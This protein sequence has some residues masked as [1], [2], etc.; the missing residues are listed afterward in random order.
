MSKVDFSIL[1]VIRFLS[2]CE[3]LY[4]PEQLNDFSGRRFPVL[5]LFYRD[6]HQADIRIFEAIREPRF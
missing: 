3:G 1:T 4:E 6:F 2:G 5:R